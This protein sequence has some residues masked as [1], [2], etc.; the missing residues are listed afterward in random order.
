MRESLSALELS[1][2]TTVVES[3]VFFSNS[4][5][6]SISTTLLSKCQSAYRPYHS[7]K[8]AV[9]KIASD[10]LSATE[11]GEVMLLGR[12][13]VSAAFD[14]VDHDILLKRLRMSFGIRGEALSWII[15]FVRQSTQTVAVNGE[16]SE[17]RRRSRMVR[18]F[19]RAASSVRFCS[20][21]IRRTRHA[22]SRCT[23][24]TSTHWPNDSE[25]YI[26]SKADEI[27]LTHPRVA[28][29]IDDIDRWMS[30]I[31]IKLNAYKHSSSYSSR[32]CCFPRQNVTVYVSAA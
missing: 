15:S 27:S 19:P 1:F 28:S 25:L 18:V 4:F 9:L 13:D 24:S 31:R 20:C 21:S 5:V 17:K 32:G 26:H 23:V 22:S 8:T 6:S 3:L 11:K 16:M 7:T 10:A 29:C 30:L 2:M 12:L 14:T